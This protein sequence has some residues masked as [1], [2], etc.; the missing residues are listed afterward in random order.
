MYFAVMERLYPNTSYQYETGGTLDG[1]R[2]NNIEKVR[3]Y[4]A[5]YY[6]PENLMIVVNGV[7]E[8]H[9]VFECLRKTEE[10]ILTRRQFT[11]LEAFHNL[12]NISLIKSDQSSDSVIEVEYPSDD[13]LTGF[14][15]N[16]RTNLL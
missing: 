12:W 3:K 8:A 16:S 13:K 15:S 9:K 6:R 2:K 7:V 1:L 11:S 10:G 5:K 4:H 14:A